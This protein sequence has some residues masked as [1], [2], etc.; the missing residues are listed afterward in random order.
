MGKWLLFFLSLV[1]ILALVMVN[2]CSGD[3]SRSTNSTAQD[4][5]QTSILPAGTTSSSLTSSVAAI[6][7]INVQ[8]AFKLILDNQNNQ[9]F[10][11]IDVRTADEFNSGHIANSINIDYYSPDFKSK[12]DKL[13]R[14][15]EYLVYCRTGVRS[16]AATRIILDLGF[17][18][19]RNMTG[20]IVQW[21]GS[22]YPTVK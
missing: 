13:D 20:G 16:A 22:G 15:K 9:D 3:V 2:G 14:S 4:A 1:L 11:I 5:T 19:V 6:P 8:D 7:E 18:K 12:L 21:T 17:T 10:V